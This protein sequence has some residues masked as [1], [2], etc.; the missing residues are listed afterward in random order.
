MTPLFALGVA[1]GAASGGVSSGMA[2]L[3]S[4]SLGLYAAAVIGVGVAIGGLWRASLAAEVVALLVVATYLFDLLA[5]A[6]GLPDSIHQLALTAH[7]GEPMVGTWD[8]FG[9]GPA[10]SWRSAAWARRAWA[11]AGAT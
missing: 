1:A 11:S 10:P 9:S 4:I 5:P 8:W 2:F 7:L 6:L 3:G